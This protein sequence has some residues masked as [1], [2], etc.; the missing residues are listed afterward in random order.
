MLYCLFLLQKEKIFQRPFLG[1][2]CCILFLWLTLFFVNSDGLLI[3]WGFWAHLSFLQSCSSL[4]FF[5]SA[6]LPSS[7][8]I[9]VFKPSYIC[10]LVLFLGHHLSEMSAVF[11]LIPLHKTTGTA[12]APGPVL[13]WPLR[14]HPQGCVWLSAVNSHTL[15][16]VK[17]W[18]H[19]SQWVWKVLLKK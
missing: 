4:S 6:S 13:C 16:H 5:S 1:L 10:T 11:F 8:V 12:T 15:A 9:C 18:G 2:F 3:P 7:S 14:C 17:T 19:T